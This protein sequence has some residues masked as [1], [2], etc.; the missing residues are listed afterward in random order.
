MGPD[1]GP[2]PVL[3]VGRIGRSEG[4]EMFRWLNSRAKSTPKTAKTPCWRDAKRQ[5]SNAVSPS[6]GG[7]RDPRPLAAYRLGY[8][9]VVLSRV[10]ES[11][12]L[13]F[14]EDEYESECE[15]LTWTDAPESDQRT[16][17]SSRC[18]GGRDEVGCFQ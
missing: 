11:F 4:I 5:Q 1:V 8:N 2:L 7:D 6:P 17:F 15:P 3:V 12:W 13:G 14:Y 16:P 9:S 18:P 10:H